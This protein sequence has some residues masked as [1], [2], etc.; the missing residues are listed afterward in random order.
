MNPA[1]ETKIVMVW[2]LEMVTSPADAM[3]TLKLNGLMVCSGQRIACRDRRSS[4]W[5]TLS[6]FGD[7][8]QAPGRQEKPAETRETRMGYPRQHLGGPISQKAPHFCEA[9]QLSKAVSQPLTTGH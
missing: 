2:W 3:M 4:G 7:Q 6:R 5:E 8:A 9:F 1:H